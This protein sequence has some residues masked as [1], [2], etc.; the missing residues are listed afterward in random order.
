MDIQNSGRVRDV[1]PLG[2]LKILGLVCSMGPG[3][4]K[5]INVPLIYIFFRTQTLHFECLEADSQGFRIA[6]V[7]TRADS[8]VSW[9]EIDAEERSSAAITLWRCREFGSLKYSCQD[10]STMADRESEEVEE[11]F[12]AHLWA[13]GVT[14]P[15]A[16]LFY[17]WD[18][19]SGL[20]LGPRNDKK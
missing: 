14:V 8:L 4:S 7:M 16:Y 9:E 15:G 1:P 10:P 5:P 18:I 12:I 13:Q 11:E 6:W 2:I 19:S 3:F 17:I 20:G